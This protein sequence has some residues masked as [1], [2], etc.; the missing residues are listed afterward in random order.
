[1]DQSNSRVSST[2]LPYSP[3]VRV[4]GGDSLLFVSG[5]LPVNPKTGEIDSIDVAE[6]TKLA[7]NNALQI[8]REN[9]SSVADVVRVGI[10]TTRL[11]EVS[12]INSSYLSILGDHRPARSLVE[13]SA[14]PRKALIEIEMVARVQ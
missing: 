12:V 7:M 3:A 1:M 14:L 10:F 8:V 6:Q 13:V 11:S 9:G 4:Q 5:Q 2:G